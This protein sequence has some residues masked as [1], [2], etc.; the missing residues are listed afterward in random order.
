[1]RRLVDA[2][3][4]VAILGAVVLGVLKLGHR[5]DTTSNSLAKQDSEL[6]QPVVR[7]ASHHGPSRR[8]IE[9]AGAGIAGAVVFLL[10]LSSAG[11]ATRRRRRQHW[12]AT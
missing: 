7:H 2:V 8:T 4:V 3:L 12:R 9:I 5:V 6:T 1:M 10:L 11:A